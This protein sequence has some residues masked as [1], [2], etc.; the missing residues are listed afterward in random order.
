MLPFDFRTTEMREMRVVLVWELA[1]G[2]LRNYQTPLLAHRF[3]KPNFYKYNCSIR[4]L[5]RCYFRI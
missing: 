1:I 5:I 3:L 2:K 4:P